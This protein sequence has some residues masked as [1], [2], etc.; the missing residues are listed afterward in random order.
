MT[1]T[2]TGVCVIPHHDEPAEAFIGGL[3]RRAWTQLVRQV[4][5]LPALANWLEAN[6]AAGGR[7]ES[8]RVKGTKEDPIPIRPAVIDTQAE[9]LGIVNAWAR[10]IAEERNLQGPWYV[11]PPDSTAERD[12]LRRGL[13]QTAS[14]NE[15][16]SFLGAHLTWAAEQPWVDDLYGEIGQVTSRAQ[17]VM[18]FRAARHDLNAPCPNPDCTAKSL[19]RYDGDF[20]VH[21]RSCGERW[22]EQEWDRLGL[23]LH[24]EQAS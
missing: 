13:E 2:E 11:L 16:C 1:P 10:L 7:G 19:S 12:R 23:I 22:D 24:E 3:C 5:E 14:L 20:Y 6:L 9:M 4:A 18:P 17:A 8:Q 15:L 21:C